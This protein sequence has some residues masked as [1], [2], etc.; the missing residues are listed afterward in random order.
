MDIETLESLRTPAGRR[1][2]AEAVASYGIED[3]FT[4][5]TR[6]RRDHPPALVAAAL[7]QARLRLRARAKADPRAL[8]RDALAAL[9]AYFHPVRGGPDGTGWPFGRAVVGGEVYAVLQRLA[10]VDFVEEVRLFPAD[11]VER[12]REAQVDR[13]DLGPHD[14]VF[15]FGHHVMVQT[16]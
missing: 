13:L 15:S 2:L 7:T 5:G 8:E 9:Y 10:G 6:L 11:P 12:S 14:L 16:S 3:G 1:L 4:L